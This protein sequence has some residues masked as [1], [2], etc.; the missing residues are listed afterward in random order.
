MEEKIE[1]KNGVQITL[2]KSKIFIDPIVSTKISIISHAHG[3]H[4]PYLVIDEP[5]TT[6]E[7]EE[8]IKVKYPFFRAK[9][10]KY[11]KKMK[12][13]E[14]SI[15]FIDAK[16]ILGSSMILIE[17]EESILYTGDFK[18]REFKKEVDI[19]IIEATYG[20]PGLVFPDRDEEIEKMIKWIN[21]QKIYKK[22]EIGVYPIGK[23]QEIIKILNEYSIF[24]SVTKTIEKFN[25]VYKKF[26]EKIETEKKSDIIIRPF[27]ETLSN[28]LPNHIH[29]L[30]TG[31]AL[32]NK[33][34]MK[35]FIISDHLDFKGLVEFIESVNPKK[36]Y[37]FH[38]FSIELADYLNKIGIKAF[39]LI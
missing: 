21:S 10:L 5:L 38:G 1:Y 6:K 36:V 24:P 22:I 19:L 3:D 15:E 34:D 18:N 39:P 13:D 31:R 11:N 9:N 32:I 37:T 2:N 29:C 17:N 33:F 20:K 27:Y 7:T 28:P 8:L 4:C 25:N 16:H 14:F 35:T 26:G 30:I 23:A 12:I